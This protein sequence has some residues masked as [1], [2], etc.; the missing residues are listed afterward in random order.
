MLSP[1]LVTSPLRKKFRTTFKSLINDFEED[2]E[3][4]CLD[5]IG[6]GGGEEFNAIVM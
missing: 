3:Q 2:E 1:K 5:E 6:G 4:T